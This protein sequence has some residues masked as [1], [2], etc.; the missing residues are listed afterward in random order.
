MQW[1]RIAWRG[2]AKALNSAEIKTKKGR[3]ESMAK[4]IH[5]KITLTEGMLGT[6]PADTRVYETYIGKNA[7]NAATLEEEIEALGT[8]AVAQRGMT[9]FPRT[10]DGRPFLYDYMIKGF[11]KETCSALQRLV[12]KDPETGRRIKKAVNESSKLGFTTYKTIVD[13]LI[14]VK[15]REIPIVFDGEVTTCQRSLRAETMQG[16]RV[17]L[18][19]SEEVPAGATLD[20][21]VICFDDSYIAAVKEWLDHGE[22]H[23]L[24]QWRNSG[25]G[26]FIYE[27]LEEADGK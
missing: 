20:F 22:F 25:K 24:G 3:K 2:T 1:H 9:V 23:G 12:P 19:C 18:A 11:F 14:F 21:W 5:V 8:E 26:T 17:S 10:E 15:P 6:S 27:I 4:K 13:T 16:P 7:P